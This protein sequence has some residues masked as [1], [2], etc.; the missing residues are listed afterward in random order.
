MDRLLT[1]VGVE[2][3]ADSCTTR[4]RLSNALSQGDQGL[5]VTN[6]NKVSY[7]GP[8]LMSDKEELQICNISCYIPLL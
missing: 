1:A 7:Y 3:D 6:L 4:M 5:S 8:R 2:I